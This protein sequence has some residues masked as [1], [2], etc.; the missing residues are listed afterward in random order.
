MADKIFIVLCNS[1]KHTVP[2][3]FH[4]LWIPGVCPADL[5]TVPQ[6]VEYETED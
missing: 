1:G 4:I 2:V 6:T 5:E 3:S